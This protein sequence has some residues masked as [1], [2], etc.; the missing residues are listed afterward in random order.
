M[1]ERDDAI[2]I[3]AFDSN[4]TRNENMEHRNELLIQLQAYL[5][6][7]FNAFLSRSETILVS[8]FYYYCSRESFTLENVSG[9]I[10]GIPNLFPLEVSLG[11]PAM[12]KKAGK[13]S[14]CCAL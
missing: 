12:T 1:V 10:F 4:T 3:V 13:S 11:T 9:K 7:N 5:S 14:R 2:E 6:L 8:A